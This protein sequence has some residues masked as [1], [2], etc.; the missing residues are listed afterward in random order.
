VKIGRPISLPIFF[1]GGALHRVEMEDQEVVESV[2][3]GVRT[4][5]YDRGRYSP[6]AKSATHHFHLPFCR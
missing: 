1:V 4:R 2:Q 6:L 3:R 5:V